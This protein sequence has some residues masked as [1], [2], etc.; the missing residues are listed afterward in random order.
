MLRSLPVPS[1]HPTHP[2]APAILK[3]LKDAQHQYAE[4]RGKWAVKVLEVGGRRVIDRADNDDG[5]AV[6]K[7]LGEWIGSFVTLLEV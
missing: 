1:T 7:T 4:T 5:I 2:A 6:G 3:Y